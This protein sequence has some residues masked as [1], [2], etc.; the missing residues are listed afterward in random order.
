MSHHRE[1]TSR[2]VLLIGSD[3]GKPW[4]LLRAAGEC[5]WVEGCV[6]VPPGPVGCLIQP[7]K[8]QKMD[9][10]M[11]EWMDGFYYA[12]IILSYLFKKKNCNRSYGIAFWHRSISVS[13]FPADITQM[14]LN[15]LVLFSPKFI[16]LNKSS[17]PWRNACHLLPLCQNSTQGSHKMQYVSTRSVED[18]SPAT[19]KMSSISVKLT[20]V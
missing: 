6:G 11:T 12:V 10:W 7:D 8:Q 3:L 16:F 5:C 2:Q 4:N 13:Y 1:K 20:E 9:R 17:I 18:D 19:S 14:L 15:H